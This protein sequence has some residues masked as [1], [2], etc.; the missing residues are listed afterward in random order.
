M[1]VLAKDQGLSP[2]PVFQEGLSVGFWAGVQIR[3]SRHCFL[4]YT[5][6]VA[7]RQNGVQLDFEC[8]PML[9]D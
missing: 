5:V 4:I 2:K 9:G 8:L 3:S 6:L 7:R 1:T